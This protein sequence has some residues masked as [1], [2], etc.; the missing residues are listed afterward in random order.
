M[1]DV[2]D[3][4]IEAVISAQAALIAALDAGQVSE[5]EAATDAMGHALV[6][7]RSN[8][9][10]PGG[11]AR[12]DHALRQVEAARIRV[13]YLA[14]RNRQ[15]LARC[16]ERRGLRAVTTYTATGGLGLSGRRS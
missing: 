16:A 7:L 2:V 13:N 3:R 14:D 8:T 4:S 10:K 15:K 1:N 12:L 9:V 11:R 5:I 6:M